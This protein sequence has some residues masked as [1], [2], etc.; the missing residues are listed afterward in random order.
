MRQFLTGAKCA[1]PRSR[2]SNADLNADHDKLDP[3]HTYLCQTSQ[4]TVALVETLQKLPDP[5]TL[6]F[7]EVCP[8][9]W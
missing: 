3:G 1:F 8:T 2:Y 6:V 7:G 4:L 9:S 5:E